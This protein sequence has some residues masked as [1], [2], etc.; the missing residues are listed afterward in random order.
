MP[1]PQAALHGRFVGLG[2][3]GQ[4]WSTATTDKQI[5]L[6]TSHGWKTVTLPVAPADGDSVA[7]NGDTVVAVGF[8]SGGMV[9]QSSTDLGTTWSTQ[10]VSS[11]DP[12]AAATVAVSP[13]TG[14]FVAGVR[15]TVRIGA[16]DG[17]GPA[18]VGD[19]GSSIRQITMPGDARN[20]GWAGDALVVPA[21]GA[22][23][24]SLFRS[25]DSGNTWADLTKAI[26][27]SVP[28]NHDIP[29][30]LPYFGPVLTLGDGT[31]VVLEETLTDTGLSATVLHFTADT[32]YTQVVSLS[33]RGNL[34]GGPVHLVSSTYGADAIAIAS[35]DGPTITVV[36]VDGSVTAI[37]AAGLPAAPDAISFQDETNGLAQVTVSGCTGDKTDCTSTSTMYVTTDGGHSWSAA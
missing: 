26:T 20:A 10:T 37:P 11:D 24:H 15:H 22:G 19:H 36:G 16:V 34:D 14:R 7:V 23:N 28:P 5:T 18:Y 21:G 9:V 32:T 25:D 13:T 8:D 27:G 33:F 29:L 3:S 17:P 6:R 2:R 4:A 30:T 1:P 12:S 35:L 31:A